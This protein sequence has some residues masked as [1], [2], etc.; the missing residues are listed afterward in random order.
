MEFKE[1][2]TDTKEIQITKDFIKIPIY[3]KDEK[4]II[5][6]YPSKDN[7]NIVFK[8]E[9]DK[10]LTFYFFEKYDLKDFKQKNKIFSKDINIKEIFSRLTDIAKKYLIN[11][12]IKGI[13]MNILFKNIYTNDNFKFNL[14]KRLVS[15]SKINSLLEEQL[16]DNSTKLNIFRNQIIKLDKSRQIK[17]DLIN[18][19][20]IRLSNINNILNNISIINTNNNSAVINLSS[21][22]NSSSNESNSENNSNN[23][24]EDEYPESV[25]SSDIG[26]FYQNQKQDS[27]NNN[28]KKESKNNNSDKTSSNN[29]KNNNDKN[30]NNLDIFFCFEKNDPT[31]NKKIIEF[32]IILN[33]I[34]IIVVIYMLCSIYTIRTNSDSEDLDDDNDINNSR[35]AYLSFLNNRREENAQKFGDLF[36]ED[37]QNKDDGIT[38]SATNNDYIEKKKKK[39]PER[40][41]YFTNDY[42]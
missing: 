29:N 5:N 1:N 17:N 9:K 16:T 6:I 18:N 21:T 32:L 38:S 33:I 26:H 30:K 13:H 15:Q 37:L 7:I 22:K 12:E 40:Y 34:T 25:N 31:Q 39:A 41:I 36:Q 14:K 3:Y 35:L 42:Y 20:N 27:T 10:V 19:I 8:L 4:Y 23:N 24:N 28:N 11:L 2:E